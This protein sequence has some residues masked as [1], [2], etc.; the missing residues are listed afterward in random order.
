MIDRQIARPIPMPL[1]FVVKKASNIWSTFF[2]SIPVPESF[3]RYCNAIR[4]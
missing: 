3:D 4:S 2:G 1:D